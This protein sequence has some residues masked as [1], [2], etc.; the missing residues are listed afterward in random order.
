MLVLIKENV[1][2]KSRPVKGIVNLQGESKTALKARA[3]REAGEGQTVTEV[4]SRFSS[5]PAGLLASAWKQVTMAADAEAK[6]ATEAAKEA[7]KAAGENPDTVEAVTPNYDTAEACRQFGFDPVNA[8]AWKS[9]ILAI[10][11][12]AEIL[13]DDNTGDTDEE[14][15]DV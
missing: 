14:E 7:A 8:G 2:G 11:P 12:K 13:P 6:E 1:N 3:M 5:I 4:F 10:N 15:F 9:A